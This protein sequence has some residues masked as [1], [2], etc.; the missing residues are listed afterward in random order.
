MMKN[1]LLLII[2]TAIVSPLYPQYKSY[3]DDLHAIFIKPSLPYGQNT[4]DAPVFINQNLTLNPLPQNEPSVRFSTKDPDIIV[5]AWRDFRLGVDPSVRRIGYTRSTNGGL[6]WAV[7]QLL[8]DPNPAHDSQSDPVIA[9]DS[10]GDF[11][12]SST[13]RQP[14]PGFN[15]EM[16][17]YKSTDAGQTF[18]LFSIAVPGSGGAGE[19][20]EWIFCDPV[21]TNPTYNNLFISWTS[22]GPSRGIKFRKSS[23]AGLNWSSTVSVSPSVSAQGSNICS[24]A[25]GE[26]F[27]VW[28]QSGI[29]FDRSTNGGTSFGTDLTISSE[30]SNNYG[31]FPFICVDYSQ[32]SRRGHVY[33]VFAD[34]RNG[35]G[36]IW[37][38]KSTNGGVNWLVNPIRVNNDVTGDQFWPVV[39]CD[40]NGDLYVT[41]YDQQTGLNSY[42]ARSTDGGFTWTNEILSDM[43]FFGNSP[44]SEVRFGDYI[45]MDVHNG[46]VVPVWT[47]DR[48]GGDNQ[49]IYSA[50]VEYSVG[51]TQNSSAVPDNYSLYQNYPNPFNPSTSIKF[52]IP[53]QSLVRI[54]VYDVIGREVET[55]VNKDLFSG[56]YSVDWN[57]SAF[58]SGVYFYRI[59]AGQYTEIKKM[60]LIK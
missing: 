1:F 60:M 23:N 10:A 47:D 45:E 29:K 17:L 25:N 31:S 50:I 6:T 11:Y 32:G 4:I 16:L 14:V 3:S 41:Y 30:S 28:W 46:R 2:F 39:R 48:A 36:D 22:F 49:E 34:D 52:D 51:I 56:E 55:L 42:L 58:P 26:I 21:P 8:P 12:I 18:T 37:L 54:S 44:N 15:R 27:I 19:D 53:K 9:C 7:P 24:G 20:K 40:I 13:S 38:Q 57:A 43:S 5:V 33:V 59:N 35:A